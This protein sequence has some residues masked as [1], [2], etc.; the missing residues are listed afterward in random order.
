VITVTAGVVEPR[1]PTF[2]GIMAAKSKPI[3]QV[4][5][6]DLGVEVTVG[7]EIV[8]VRPAPE[9]AAGE[10]IEDDGEAHLRIIQLLEQA[11]VI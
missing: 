9:R 1:Y 4:T 5:A 11:K 2:K 3:E 10:I 6:A 7:Q 8:S